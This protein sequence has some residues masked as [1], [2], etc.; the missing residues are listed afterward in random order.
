[1]IRIDPATGASE[2]VGECAKVTTL[3]YDPVTDA[4]YGIR[5]DGFHRIRPSDGASTL[6]FTQSSLLPNV[7]ALG[8]DPLTGVFRAAHHDPAS[9]DAPSMLTIDLF[10]SV[11]VD[12]DV[13]AVLVGLEMH[14]ATGAILGLGSGGSIVSLTPGTP[15]YGVLHRGNVGTEL[16]DL[17]LDRA[18]GGYFGIDTENHLVKLWLDGSSR[19]IGRVDVPTRKLVFDSNDRV[20]WGIGSNEIFTSTDQY[21]YEIDAATAATTTPVLTSLSVGTALTFDWT[22]DAIRGISGVNDVTI[23]LDPI[24][25]QTSLTSNALGFDDVL[26]LAWD[27]ARGRL[28]AMTQ[29]GASEVRGFFSWEPLVS[30]P[31]TLETVAEVEARSLAPVAG[32]DRFVSLGADGDMVEVSL[33]DGEATIGAVRDDFYFSTTFAP[34]R[35]RV[36]AAAHEDVFSIDP[37]TGATT[38]VGST[39]GQDRPSSIAWDAE[40]G[41]LGFLIDDEIRWTSASAPWLSSTQTQLAGRSVRHLAFSAERGVFYLL[42]S[43]GL[44]TLARNVG[45]DSFVLVDATPA[46][47][48]VTDV[49]WRDGALWAA[50]SDQVLHRIDPDTGVWTEVGRMRFGMQGLH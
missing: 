45:G 29:D 43:D 2:D 27:A 38:H 15:E 11:D 14:S 37:V 34:A 42:G 32:S 36:F 5:S 3:T 21:V 25:G 4:L 48:D 31:G 33:V 13:D 9:T 49:T 6:L 12:G 19:T 40:N 20:L 18:D 28:V 26:G 44:F 16:F 47:T 39:P 46:P 17:A 50:T 10:G 24:T 1:L 35:G 8:L 30:G 23:E 22:N 41:R 7:T